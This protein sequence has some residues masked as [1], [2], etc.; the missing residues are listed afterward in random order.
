MC[1]CDDCEEESDD[2]HFLDFEQENVSSSIFFVIVV[3]N[4]ENPTWNPDM[5][6]LCGNL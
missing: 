1:Y 4:F 2:E 5:E 6:N 3:I